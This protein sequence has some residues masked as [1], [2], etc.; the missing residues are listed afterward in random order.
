M[1]A[2][3]CISCSVAVVSSPSFGNVVTTEASCSFSSSLSCSGTASFSPRLRSCILSFCIKSSLSA[4]AF[5]WTFSSLASNSRLTTATAAV[6]SASCEARALFASASASAA[7][8]RA[9]RFSSCAVSKAFISSAILFCPICGSDEVDLLC[10]R[11][12]PIAMYSSSR[13]ICDRGASSRASMRA[14]AA[15][16]LPLRR[17]SRACATSISAELHPAAR[18]SSIATISLLASG[19]CD[20]SSRRDADRRI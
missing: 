7:A 18:A 1:S 15:L 12:S 20:S 17:S 13:S 6:V 5:A 10:P 14:R 9:L 2:A 16:L 11:A 3:I 4:S 19:D 8:C